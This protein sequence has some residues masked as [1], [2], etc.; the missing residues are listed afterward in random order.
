M[1]AE[2]R[3]H[4][5]GVRSERPPVCRVLRQRLREA[6]PTAT[7]RGKAGH[8]VRRVTTCSR[9]PGTKNVGAGIQARLRRYFALGCASASCRARSPRSRKTGRSSEAR[10]GQG[11]SS[12]RGLPLEW[13]E[14]AQ[15]RLEDSRPRKGMVVAGRCRRTCLDDD[16]VADIGRRVAAGARV[17]CRDRRRESSTSRSFRLTSAN[18]K[19]PKNSHASPTPIIEGDRVYV[20]FG[21]DGTAAI[22]A[23]SGAIVW[24]AQFPYASQHGS[25]GSPALYK[26]LLIFSARRSL[27]SVRHRARQAHRQRA[28]EDASAASRSIRRTRR[29]S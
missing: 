24:K 20:H 21:G 22:D 28:V 23:A 11:H 5:S 9:C 19:N 2:L 17:R 14:T 13:S 12:E 18:L 26:D 29:R 4:P 7:S 15:C 25:G 16:R 6:R 3:R 1:D 10:T 27:R 8:R